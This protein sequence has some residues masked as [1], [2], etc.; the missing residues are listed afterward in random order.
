MEESFAL[1]A[2]VI[3]GLVTYV[4]ENFAALGMLSSAVSLLDMLLAFATRVMSSRGVYTR[5]EFTAAGPLAVE[6]G[7]HP[8]LEVGGLYKLN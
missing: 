2:R 8:M 4:R 5:P 6:E 3:E 7:R 1:S